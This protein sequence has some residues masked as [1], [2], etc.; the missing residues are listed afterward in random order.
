MK[1]LVWWIALLSL[2]A[3]IGAGASAQA[4]A[5]LDDNTFYDLEAGFYGDAFHGTL[6]RLELSPKRMLLFVPGA[7]THFMPNLVMMD[8]DAGMPADDFDSVNGILDDIVSS[9][10]SAQSEHED[11]FLFNDAMAEPY[12][13][14]GLVVS[15][16][17]AQT[18]RWA[19][20]GM[21]LMAPFYF[22]DATS[23]VRVDNPYLLSIVASEGDGTRYALYNEPRV[24]LSYLQQVALDPDASA[25]QAELAQWQAQSPTVA[26]LGE[27]LGTVTVMS[28]RGANVRAQSNT[29]AEIVEGVRP[30]QTFSVV[31]IAP[32]GWYEIALG[33]GR[34]GF[35]APGMVSFR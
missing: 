27:S 11:I 31:S 28:E 3:G 15:L 17:D 33:D 29:D 8:P 10:M 7:A 19:E 30:G 23:F 26:A 25:F 32:N 13:E 22:Q 4:G 9:V 6:Q 20:D 1:K 35:I 34:T 24:V 16:G 14:N 18:W 12:A 21:G 5:T 2:V